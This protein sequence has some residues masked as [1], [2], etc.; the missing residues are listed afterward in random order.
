MGNVMWL[1][2]LVYISL[3]VF[4]CGAVVRAI[5]HHRQP[6]HLRWEL[7]TGG[8]GDSGE[9]GR[10][11]FEQQEWWTKPRKKYLAHELRYMAG[12]I[13]F[14]NEC[15]RRNRTLW[16]FTYSLHLGLYLGIL[17]LILLACGAILVAVDAGGAVGSGSASGSRM[18]LATLTCGVLSFLLGA[19]GSIGLL[20]RRLT[21]EDVKLYSTPVD[22]FNLLFLGVLFMSGLAVWHWA[23][24][25]FYATRGYI[26]HLLALNPAGPMDPVLILFL[27]VLSLFV[28]YLPFTPMMHFLGK[29]F[30][31][32]RVRWDDEPNVR[33]GKIEKR[34]EEMLGQ[35]VNWSGGHIKPGSTWVEA[36]LSPKS[37]EEK[38][39]TSQK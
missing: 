6:I 35:H 27:T 12:E 3:F 21:K 24:P 23:D 25:T 29:Y 38:G 22:Y 8:Y 5:R 31:Y 30:M 36:A 17:W 10:S 15:Y 26:A 14:F 2:A 13:F 18:Y 11:C 34:V 19:F 28:L 39:D 37:A 16:Y 32:H 4:F 9:H 20:I 1:S 7:H 33:G